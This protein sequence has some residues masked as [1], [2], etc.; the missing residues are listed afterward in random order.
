LV[1]RFILDNAAHWIREYHVDGLRLDATHALID[2]SPKK[3]VQ[4]I[5]EHV[6]QEAGRPIV[7]HAEDH[8]N[9]AEMVEDTS[10]GGWGIDG[11]W[12]D[13]FH[14]VVRRMLAGDADSYY[15]DFAG[16]AP[17]LATVIQRGWLYIGG[18]SEHMKGPRGTDP[19]RVPMHRFVVCVQNHDQVGNRALGDRLHHTIPAETWRAVSVL[20]MIVP[21]TPLLFMGQE[22]AASTPFQYFTDLEPGLGHLVTEGRRREFA[23]FPA[24]ARHET[25][26]LI[27]DPQAESTFLNSRLRWTEQTEAAH[28]RSLALYRALIALRREHPALTGSQETSGRANAP[29]DETIVVR[30]DGLGG[31]FWIVARFKSAGSVDLAAV[32][33]AG[34][35]A[36]GADFETVLDTEHAE[37]ADAPAA[38]D[39]TGSVVRFDRPGAVILKH[40]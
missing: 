28:R 37:Y 16:R 5:A 31:T 6:R 33:G 32:A 14:H 35:G 34:E 27:P 17:E 8:R 9:L 3:I 25:R 39:I 7:V 40:R 24:F 23:D 21:M 10:I 2:Q 4:E 12:A 18:H 30:R 38:I 11:V 19:V 13:D 36:E 20:L 1:R 29:D 26:E 15:A 22:W